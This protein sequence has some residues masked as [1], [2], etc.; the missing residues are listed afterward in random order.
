MLSAY[1]L[2]FPNRVIPLTCS[3]V[4][5]VTFL[6]R[7]Y[8]F[9]AEHVFL[10][11]QFF[12]CRAF[13][14]MPSSFSFLQS[15][16]LLCRVVLL[17]WR[18][19]FSSAQHYSAEKKKNFFLEKENGRQRRK[20]TRQRRK[21]HGREE[22]LLDIEGKSSAEKKN[23]SAEQECVH[24][25][26]IVRGPPHPR[27]PV[28][29]PRLL[30]R[31]SPSPPCLN[32]VADVLDDFLTS[33]SEGRKIRQKSD[34][35]SLKLMENVEMWF[36]HFNTPL[37]FFNI[38]PYFSNPQVALICIYTC[39]GRYYSPP[40]SFEQS[41]RTSNRRQCK[42]PNLLLRINFGVEITKC[43]QCDEVLKQ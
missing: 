10:A 18:A 2:H 13:S 40:G 33:L 17:L 11:E 15:T 23:C 41:S 8:F 6:L 20:I 9:S 36:L 35:S 28:A 29:V 42:I 24:H 22:K 43:T 32:P 19:L 16:C 26:S 27:I 21:I 4:L 7:A 12:L 1:L 39:Y 37:Q 25:W 31:S 5:V 3:F 30:L 38:L 14:L 34:T